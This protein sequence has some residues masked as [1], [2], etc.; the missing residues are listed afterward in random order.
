MTE[1]GKAGGMDSRPLLLP[2]AFSGMLSLASHTWGLPWIDRLST[3]H[4]T[5]VTSATIFV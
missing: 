5:D 1:E 2:T 3:S 4:A